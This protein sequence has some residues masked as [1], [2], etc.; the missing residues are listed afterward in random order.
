MKLSVP[1]PCAAGW[2]NMSPSGNGRYCSSCEKI[3]V[4][5]TKMSNEEI[6][7]YFETYAD[8]KTCG[9]F[10]SSQLGQKQYG[11]LAQLVLLWH[12][13][14]KGNI[15]YKTPRIAALFILGS[16]LALMGCSS[17]NEEVEG[18]A[19]TGDSISMSATDTNVT[20]PTPKK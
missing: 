20:N 3:V 12:R 13:K 14:S 19:V 6:K 8:Q 10:Y 1:N 5:F 2:D 11:K 9:H 7:H 16:V 15:R 17:S 4:D 18:K